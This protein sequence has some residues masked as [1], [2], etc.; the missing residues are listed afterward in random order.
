MAYLVVL[1]TDRPREEARPLLYLSR[2][3]I[4]R[5]LWHGTV[6]FLPYTSIVRAR[7][8]GRTQIVWDETDAES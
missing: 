5:K 6:R 4:L 8:E 3:G 7:I 1:W 2:D